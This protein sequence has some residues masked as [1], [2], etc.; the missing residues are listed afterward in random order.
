MNSKIA[1]TKEP[2][3]LFLL[4]LFAFLEVFLSGVITLLIAPD[5]KNALIFGFSFQRLLL[6]GGI[7][8]LAIIVLIAGIMA[9]KKKATLDSAWRFNKK[10]ILRFPIYVLFF[11]LIIWGWLS[12]FCPAYHDP[13]LFTL[14][15]SAICCIP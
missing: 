2:Q 5:P 9:R 15:P 12:L 13:K 3:I 10:K 1:P 7:W 11:I 8:I 6:V 14:I 4:S